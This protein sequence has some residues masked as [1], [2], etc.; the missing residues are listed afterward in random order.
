MIA[1]SEKVPPFAEADIL[2]LLAATY[3][4]LCRTLEAQGVLNCALLARAMAVTTRTDDQ[5]PWAQLVLAL[6][7]ALAAPAAA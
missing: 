3:L 1:G 2:R 6:S 4:P 5:A 7:D